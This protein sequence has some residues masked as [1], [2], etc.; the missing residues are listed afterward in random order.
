MLCNGVVR[1]VESGAATPFW[2]P[3]AF[4]HRERGAQFRMDPRNSGTNVGEDKLRPSSMG[5]G[6]TDVVLRSITQQVMTEIAKSSGERSY[7]IKKFMQM[8]PPSFA[9]GDDPIIAENWVRGIEETLAVLSC[10][11]EQK[12]VFATFKLTGEAKRRTRSARLIEEQRLV[13]VLVTWDRFKD[14]FFEQ[15]FP[16]IIWST[17][18][19][20]FM[21][22]EHGQMTVSQYATRFI[23]LSQFAPH[24]APNEEK[25]VRKFAEGLRQNLFK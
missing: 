1:G 3:G 14:L 6:D 24:L 22:L 11:D 10:T 2:G 13:L 15:Y 16:T 8:K 18:A 7:T 25:K 19:A 9:R 21:L 23:K 5:G 12:M 20:V 17:K 4:G